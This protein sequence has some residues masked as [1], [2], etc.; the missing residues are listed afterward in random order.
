M[1]TDQDILNLEFQTTGSVVETTFRRSDGDVV[2]VDADRCRGE[3]RKWMHHFADVEC[4]LFVV[5]LSGYD[6]CLVEDRDAVSLVCLVRFRSIL[7]I[8]SSN[9]ESD[10][11][12]AVY[13]GFDMQLR[14]VSAN[15]LGQLLLTIYRP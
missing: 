5:N 2:I 7:R 13:M 10:A 8:R 4:I 6:E 1:P 12:C 15:I 3:R 11:R 9:S 14:V